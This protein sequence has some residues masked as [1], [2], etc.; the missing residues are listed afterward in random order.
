MIEFPY[1]ISVAEVTMSLYD[2]RWVSE[3]HSDVL[4]LAEGSFV[5]LCLLAF[6]Y[7]V[8]NKVKVTAIQSLQKMH[9]KNC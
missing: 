2:M 5:L 9:S 8:L 6:K 1:T 7:C 3:A 4:M